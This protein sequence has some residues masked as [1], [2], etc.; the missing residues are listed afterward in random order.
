MLAQ[1]VQQWY[2]VLLDGVEAVEVL[3]PDVLD[4]RLELD[5]VLHAAE[6]LAADLEQV[7]VPL[8]GVE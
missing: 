4:E 1:L 5:D 7:V 8:D 6:L 3:L 2:G